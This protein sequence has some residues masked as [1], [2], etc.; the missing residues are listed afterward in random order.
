MDDFRLT[1]QQ[2][3]VLRTLHRTLRDK[4]LADRV[5]AIVQTAAAA[6]SRLTV[7]CNRI[8]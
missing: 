7:T 3:A 4:R 6:G 2:V 1:A 5:K 8:Y